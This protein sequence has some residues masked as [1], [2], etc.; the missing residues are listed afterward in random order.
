MKLFALSRGGVKREEKDFSDIVN[1]VIENHV[2]VDGTFR[3]L[4]QQFAHDSL[5]TRLCARIQELQDA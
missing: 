5:Y 1:L 2:P 3:E 4:C